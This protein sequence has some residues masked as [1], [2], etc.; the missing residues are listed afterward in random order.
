M[1][2]S[3]MRRCPYCAEWIELER[4]KCP[5]CDS[6]IGAEGP[7]RAGPERAGPE[8]TAPFVES[9][10]DEL[11]GGLRREAES[12]PGLRDDL[13]RFGGSPAAERP[14]EPMERRG[15]KAEARPAQ[16]S[17][18]R[19][20]QADL[21]PESLATEREQ[22]AGT[23]QSWEAEFAAEPDE[24]QLADRREDRQAGEETAGKPASR[25]SWEAGR[26][27]E[28]QDQP[29]PKERRLGPFRLG[30]KQPKPE[31]EP[32]PGGPV[33]L[34]VEA[35]GLEATRAAVRV[36]AEEDRSGYA[37]LPPSRRRE[38]SSFAQLDREAL[39]SEEAAGSDGRGRRL[40]AALAR[41]LAGLLVVGAL[42]LGGFLLVR[43]PGAPLLAQLLA[44]DVPATL[45]P[46]QAPT[47][48]L[49]RAPTL[50]PESPEPAATS[51][52][53]AATQVAGPEGCVSWEQVTVANQGE[54]LCV[55]GEIRRWFSVDE[56]PFVAIFS[57]ESGTFALVDRTG[58]HPVGPGDCVM[59]S[60]VVEVM[61][62]TRPNIDVQGNLMPCPSE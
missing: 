40:G 16:P 25:H 57:E 35:T 7:E 53:A 12:G 55:Y 39:L 46:S 58:V 15:R 23:G 1:W 18:R 9:S 11:V 52:A 36:E 49:S 19:S 42:G 48:T 26:E 22:A 8:R 30:R 47:S 3:K 5:Q 27:P 59:G 51:S 43:G 44:T 13:G 29:K 45:T 34:F 17:G 2:L 4:D 24:Q 38:T 62:G 54:Q 6:V 31:P 21:T 33:P 10:L 32:E 60:G 14:V 37:A 20:W 50:P 41:T 56:V 61:R 28:P